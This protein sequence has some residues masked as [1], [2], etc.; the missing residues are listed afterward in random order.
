[1][2]AGQF[3]PAFLLMKQLNLSINKY[4][5]SLGAPEIND[6]LRFYTG[7]KHSEKTLV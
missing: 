5:R 6:K 4:I 1:M 7:N 2:Q 3:W